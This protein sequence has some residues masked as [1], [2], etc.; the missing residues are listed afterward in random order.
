MAGYA[1]VTDLLIQNGADMEARNLKGYSPFLMAA[2]NN[3]TLVMDLLY[4]R[5]VDIYAANNAH[6]NA[7]DLAISTNQAQSAKYLLK[8]G[9]KWADPHENAVDP[10]IVATKYRRKEMISLLREN[11][12]PGK[13][14]YGIDQ[15]TIMVSS[16]FTFKDYYTGISLAFKEPYL[17]AGF[18]MGCDTKFWDTRV[19]I[20][21]SEHLYH[22][23]LDKGL[24][25]YTGVFKDFMLSENPFKSNFILT[26]SVL[27]GYSFGHKLKGTAIVPPSEFKII[28]DVALKW[29]RRN[30]SLSLGV[31]Y[32]KSDFYHIGPVWCRAGCSYTIYFDRVRTH[33]TPIKWY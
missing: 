29:S 17:N 5:G 25:V 10:Y 20:K 23:Y 27:A 14:D 6:Y 30:L 3:D 24:L 26:T 15:A 4:R 11:K 8:I 16:R 28:P 9:N 33:V 31:E 18:L 22:Q 2:V 19:L 21:D 32:V 12:I 7:L 13:I 1:D